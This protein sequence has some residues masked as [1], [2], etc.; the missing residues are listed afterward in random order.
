MVSYISCY[1]MNLYDILHISPC[2]DFSNFELSIFYDF[3]K[4]GLTKSVSHEMA[5]RG[6]G[7]D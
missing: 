5:V 1:H 2:L 6:T 3:L 7:R 4:L